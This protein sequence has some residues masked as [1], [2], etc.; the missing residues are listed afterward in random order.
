MS[1]TTL[2]AADIGPIPCVFRNYANSARRY[3]AKWKTI[4]MRKDY[5]LLPDGYYEWDD[6]PV[7]SS[8]IHRN[9]L[10]VM[11]AEARKE[12]M[13]DEREEKR[14]KLLITR[15]ADKNVT[16]FINTREPAY[17]VRSSQKEEIVG[18]CKEQRWRSQHHY[19]IDD[20]LTYPDPSHRPADMIGRVFEREYVCCEC[21]RIPDPEKAV[22]FRLVWSGDGWS[23]FRPVWER[24]C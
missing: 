22:L 12:L 11:G 21:V 9:P 23:L 10:F 17:H 7:V 16:L 24:R 15:F 6:C 8:N 13:H 18:W 19:Y 1:Y 3:L 2:G 5:L 4:N 14:C 20:Y